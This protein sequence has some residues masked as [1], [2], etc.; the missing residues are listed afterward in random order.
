MEP[1]DPVI[2]RAIRLLHSNSKASADQLRTLLEEAIA[3]RKAS[4]KISSS[5]KVCLLP[6]GFIYK[7]KGLSFRQNLTQP[8]NHLLATRGASTAF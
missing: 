8:K 1:I 4:L 7:E 2:L 3:Q 5:Q 6:L